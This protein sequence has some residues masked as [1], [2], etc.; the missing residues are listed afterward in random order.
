M[1]RETVRLSVLAVGIGFFAAINS[2]Q[3]PPVAV[4]F[5]LVVAAVLFGIGMLFGY[6]TGPGGTTRWS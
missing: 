4:L 6:A 3:S 5:G 2:R 1:T